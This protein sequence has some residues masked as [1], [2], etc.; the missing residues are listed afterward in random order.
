MMPLAVLSFTAAVALLNM[1][2]ALPA[3]ASMVPEF[4]VTVALLTAPMSP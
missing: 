4:V 2:L 3:M 1:A